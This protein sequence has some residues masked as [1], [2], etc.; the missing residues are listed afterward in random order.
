MKQ[1]T[2]F[3]NQLFVYDSEPRF[4]KDL[5]PKNPCNGGMFDVLCQIT[6][7]IW[8]DLFVA[9]TIFIIM[10]NTIIVGLVLIYFGLPA[11][12][13]EANILSLPSL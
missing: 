2:N 9:F 5:I 12:L 4:L 10:I 3:N 1:W 8:H 6:I 13:G 11:L 7:G